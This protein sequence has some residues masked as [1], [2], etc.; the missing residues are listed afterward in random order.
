MIENKD[1]YTISEDTEI[2]KI[3]TEYCN[4]LYNYP[5]NPDVNT[6]INR[7]VELNDNLPILKSEV[8]NYIKYIKKGRATGVD[9]IPGKLFINGG[10]QLID[11]ITELCQ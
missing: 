8:E 9:N 10:T 11:T 6:L 7:E 3:W 4:E 2:V 1:G 5:I